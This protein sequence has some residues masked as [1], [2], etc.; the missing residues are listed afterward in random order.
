MSNSRFNRTIYVA[1]ITIAI[2]VGFL[3]HPQRSH[4]DAVANAPA[5]NAA[6]LKQER[7]ETLRKASDLAHTLATQGAITWDE[8]S[9]VDQRLL[10]AQL[11][12]ADSADARAK[13]LQ[14]ALQVARD[15]EDL[16][17]RRQRSGYVSSLVPLE[18]K[19]DRLR[20]EIELAK[21]GSH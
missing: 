17:A 4:G 12:A 21:A 16:A 7:V 9:R 15:Q 13:I 18:A 11:D 8:S 2:V 3:L 14:A 20:I 6:K 10:D 1:S 5:D 19:A